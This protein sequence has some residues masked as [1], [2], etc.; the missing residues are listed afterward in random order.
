MYVFTKERSIQCLLILFVLMYVCLCLQLC[1]VL[2]TSGVVP[3]HSSL[4]CE[5]MCMPS[6]DS[7]ESALFRL[8]VVDE[9]GASGDEGGARGDGG[10]QGERNAQKEEDNNFLTLK[11]EV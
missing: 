3:A 8:V 5:F 10:V 2:P 1:D 11:A 4:Q 6:H 9:G 7:H